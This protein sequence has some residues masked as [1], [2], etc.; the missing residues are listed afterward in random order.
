MGRR[1]ELG[2]NF[3]NLAH[4]FEE[5]KGR[6]V[7]ETK[8]EY[9]LFPMFNGYETCKLWH[10]REFLAYGNDVIF[11]VSLNNL[12][13]QTKQAGKTWLWQRGFK[14]TM[15]IISIYDAIGSIDGPVPSSL[16]SCPV[17]CSCRLPSSQSLMSALAVSWWRICWKVANR[18]IRTTF[19]DEILQA[20]Y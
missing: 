9:Y 7:F 6:Y 15:K 3:W 5:R 10:H 11:P 20:G 1:T 17:R 8:V 2:S 4:C 19:I 12:L 16:T 13:K 18:T 14:L